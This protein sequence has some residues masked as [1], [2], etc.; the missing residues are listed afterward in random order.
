MKKID[1]RTMHL[2]D[3][4]GCC[5]KCGDASTPACKAFIELSNTYARVFMEMYAVSGGSPRERLLA[6]VSA[7]IDAAGRKES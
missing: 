6:A 4:E 1:Y 3:E 5:T 2:L 7:T